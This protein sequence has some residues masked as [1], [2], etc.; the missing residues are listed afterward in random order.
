M[1]KQFG[2]IAAAAMLSAGVGNFGS[3]ALSAFGAPSLLLG[4]SADTEED[5]RRRNLAAGGR[6]KRIK[7]QASRRSL[8]KSDLRRTPRQPRTGLVFKS[9]KRQEVFY[10]ELATGAAWN[11][12]LKLARR[13]AV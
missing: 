5:R 6:D 13:V 12:A 2:L 8:R 1:R 10:N 4:L 11:E 9:N 3:K 7:K